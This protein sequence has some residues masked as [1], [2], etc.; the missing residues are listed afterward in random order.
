M[1]VE[2]APQADINH[3]AHS[4]S[5]DLTTG[6][7]PPSVPLRAALWTASRT[8]RALG[9]VR[10]ALAD[11]LG[12]AVWARSR[13]RAQRTAANHRRLQP[14]LDAANARR[15][16][17]ASFREFTRTSFDFV[18]AYAVPPQRMRRYFTTQD[19]D[20]I[21]N[22]LRTY[23]GAVIALAHYGSW[24]VAAACALYLN[25]PITTVMTTVGGS[26]LA[27]RIAAWARRKQD[28]E[29]LMTQGA[30]TGLMNAVRSGRCDAILSDIPDRGQR[31]IVDF[32]GG[33]VAFSTAPAWIAR[34]TGVP[35]MAAHC[36]RE[37][38]RY[39]LRVY[40]PMLIGESQSDADVM[41]RIASTLE[42]QIRRMPEQWYPFGRVYRN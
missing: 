38:G 31:A 5:V 24:D 36:W 30:A 16:A 41:Q 34:T 21:L 25:I 13:E 20:H 32:C 6:L 4:A 33:K 17:R 7:A 10:Y 35:I 18:W 42:P 23:N 26:D 22:A 3:T 28:L 39:V 11:A 12:V 1:T 37:H 9:P 2:S 14:S 27:T 29:V 8:L 19:I 40:P 15:R